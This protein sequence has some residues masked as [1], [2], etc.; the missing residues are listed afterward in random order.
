MVSFINSFNAYFVEHLL[1][2]G[3]ALG[4]GIQRRTRPGS[5]HHVI[6]NH[7][8]TFI[9]HATVSCSNKHHKED[10]SRVSGWRTMCWDQG[11][12]FRHVALVRPLQGGHIPFDAF[13]SF[14]SLSRRW[15]RDS[16][17]LLLRHPSAH[18]LTY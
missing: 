5:W 6:E 13:T 10:Y 18:F 7:K 15:R 9:S 3:I 1:S 12:Y 14:S 4:L 16:G 2:P 11:V 8:Y 17:P